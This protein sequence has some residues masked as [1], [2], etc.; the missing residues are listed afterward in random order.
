VFD[1][2]YQ[3]RRRRVVT[4]LGRPRAAPL[5]RA[6]RQAVGGGHGHLGEAVTASWSADGSAIVSGSKDG[7]AKVWDA[8]RLE[9]G[10]AMRGH[11]KYVYGVAFHPDGRRAASASWDG[12]VAL[13][14]LDAARRL[15]G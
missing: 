11:D 12:T 3:P 7:T 2:A 10:G 9:R 14:D 1:A 5:G 15:S 8:S 13:W 6:D 4:A